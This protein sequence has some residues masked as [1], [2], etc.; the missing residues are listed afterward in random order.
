M[1]ENT[2]KTKFFPP[3][4]V[5][6]DYSIAVQHK[7]V[8]TDVLRKTPTEK[9]LR[10]HEGE[11]L[12]H[13]TQYKKEKENKWTVQDIEIYIQHYRLQENHIDEDSRL[14]YLSSISNPK[15][16]PEIL[17]EKIIEVLS[18]NYSSILEKGIEYT[19]NDLTIQ[20]ELKKNQ[21]DNSIPCL[22]IT[23]DD[24]SL[25]MLENLSFEDNKNKSGL[26]IINRVKS[27]Y[28]DKEGC[29]LFFDNQCIKKM[30]QCLKLFPDI[31]YPN[32][33]EGLMYKNADT[34]VLA[35]MFGKEWYF[36]DDYKSTTPEGKINYELLVEY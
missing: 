4:K 1:G 10:E 29:Y 7:S 19:T 30:F 27:V 22:T 15:I 25:I 26:N 9:W 32:T 33:H 20:R 14:Y 31:C 2:I 36:V 3:N 23:D 24:K 8:E 6:K 21:K 5:G 11:T 12:E 17:G 13:H 35:S 18:R 28:K 16:L 34:E